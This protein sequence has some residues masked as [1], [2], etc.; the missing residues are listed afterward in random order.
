MFSLKL[1]IPG[2]SVHLRSPGEHQL[3]LEDV[4]SVFK[5]SFNSSNSFNPFTL[6][7]LSN[8]SNRF[9]RPWFQKFNY[10]LQYEDINQSIPLDQV[11]CERRGMHPALKFF[12]VAIVI[13]LLL[14]ITF[15]FGKQALFRKHFW[16]RMLI[17]SFYLQP[18]KLQGRA[19]SSKI[20]YLRINLRSMR[21][22]G[23]EKRSRTKVWTSSSWG[24]DCK[25]P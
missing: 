18:T 1:F 8:P 6:S 19:R 13:I 10:D 21:S 22:R 7:T 16:S 12:L 20:V 15:R 5:V 3:T 11:G 9:A 17:K 2:D 25:R 14:Q 4:A 23:R 24:Q